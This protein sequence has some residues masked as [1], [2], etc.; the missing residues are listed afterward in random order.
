M[1]KVNLIIVQC[2]QKVFTGKVETIE[3]FGDDDNGI[4]LGFNWN[5]LLMS[6]QSLEFILYLKLDPNEVILTEN[7]NIYVVD[8][9]QAIK[10]AQSYIKNFIPWTPTN[11]N[12]IDLSSFLP[13][14][15]I[16]WIQ[17]YL[18]FIK[19]CRKMDENR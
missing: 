1:W 12:Y 4:R 2:T 14:N 8:K 7:A 10:N 9:N 11:S 17:N 15:R 13:S 6:K 19:F 16:H 3:S 18:S 5:I